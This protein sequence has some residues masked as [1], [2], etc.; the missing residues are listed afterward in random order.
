MYMYEYTCSRLA[1]G[2]NWTTE[3]EGGEGEGEGS[4]SLSSLEAER[5]KLQEEVER[6]SREVALLEEEKEKRGRLPETSAD[7]DDLCKAL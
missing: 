3:V 6:L 1:H 5:R 4:L 2:G 7:H